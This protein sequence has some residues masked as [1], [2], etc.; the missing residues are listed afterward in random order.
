MSRSLWSGESSKWS[1]RGLRVD[2]A[3]DDH[4]RVTEP[5]SIDQKAS[6]MIAANAHNLYRPRPNRRPPSRRNDPPS[7]SF[8]PLL[9]VL[10]LVVDSSC[11]CDS[12]S[13]IFSFDLVTD[14]F[15]PTTT[16][17]TPSRLLCFLFKCEV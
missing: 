11:A 5:V 13:F 10:L 2:A 12:S 7:F 3:E 1:E 14:L 15:L 17:T 4:L 6:S 16:T 8:F 9:I